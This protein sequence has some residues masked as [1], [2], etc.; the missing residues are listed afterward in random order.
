MPNMAGENLSLLTD[1]ELAWLTTLNL[2]TI[3]GATQFVSALTNQ[4]FLITFKNQMQFVFK[5]L[6]L[7][8]RNRDQRRCELGVQ[9]LASCNGLSAAVIADNEKFRVLSYIKGNVLSEQAVTSGI[10]EL[11]ASQFKLIHQLPAKHATEQDLA[12]ELAHLKTQIS[13][14][15]D[16]SEYLSFLKLAEQLDEESEKNTLCHGDLSLNNIIQEENGSVKVLDW[17][18][19][20]LAC[21]AYDLGFCCAINEFNQV[22]I[23][24]LIE[25]YY[26]LNKSNLALSLTFLQKQCHLY[27]SFF[28]YLNRLWRSAF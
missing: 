20:V 14:N 10:L 23:E 19:T 13:G 1:E 4:V 22:Q 16:E 8:A 24:A 27:L 12:G 5:R 11:L 26:Q 9:N 18:Y 25:H 6:N 15:V 7:A 21:P 28:N 2:G 17:E 3:T